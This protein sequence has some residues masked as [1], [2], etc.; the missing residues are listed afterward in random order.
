MKL[1]LIGEYLGYSKS[2]DIH[3][4]YFELENI[5]STY[6]LIELAKNELDNF[7]RGDIYKYDGINVTIPYKQD[8]IP[9]LDEISKGAEALNSVNTIKIEDGKLKGFNTDL[10]G[11]KLSLKKFLI[12][13]KDKDIVILGTGATGKMMKYIGET[14]GAKS[15]KFVS[16]QDG[17]DFKYTDNIMGD[18]LINTTP[19]GT[20]GK[21]DDSPVSEE[22][23]KNFHSI[24]DINY[25]PFRTKL[26]RFGL[27]NNKKIMNGFYM[28]VAQ[29]MISEGIW[30]DKNID[31]SIIDE[32]YKRLVKNRNI[33]LIGLSGCGKST[34]SKKLSEKLNKSFISI[35][36][37][38]EKD[39][40]MPISEMF[41][42]SE[43][44]FREKEKEKTLEVSQYDNFIIDSGGGV[45]KN[46]ENMNALYKN[47]IVFYIKRDIKDIISTIDYSVRPLVKTDKENALL[48]LYNERY[49]LYE[50][51]AEFIVENEDLDES[52]NKIIK[53]LEE[54]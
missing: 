10:D 2:G 42:I 22:I 34:I 33:V 29:G 20:S 8:V 26:L 47:G 18:I 17:F 44:Y 40:N 39:F 24:I 43:E 6:D 32:V 41:E 1:G 37:K 36:D 16:R 27:Y 31:N 52:I 9:Y 51:Y 15:V 30:Q 28:L 23:V 5:N 49:K 50:K 11:F 48:A 21:D 54:I 19:K 35:D 13:L 45:I 7:M 4:T 46:E 53:R 25:N 38:I 14:E 3:N 12:P